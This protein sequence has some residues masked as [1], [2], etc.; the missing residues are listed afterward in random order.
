MCL[1][2]PV[3]FILSRNFAIV[4]IVGNVVFLQFFDCRKWLTGNFFFGFPRVSFFYTQT[5]IDGV[6]SKKKPSL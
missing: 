2:S 6:F 4:S 5:F 1:T 3:N